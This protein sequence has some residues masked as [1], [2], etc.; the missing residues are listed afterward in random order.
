M[1]DHDP[2]APTVGAAGQRFLQSA[3]A[4]PFWLLV[5]LCLLPFLLAVGVCWL[6]GFR[7]NPSPSPPTDTP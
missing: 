4:A 2:A 7:F 3:C 1:T 5:G 6:L